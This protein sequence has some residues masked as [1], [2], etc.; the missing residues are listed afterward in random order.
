M[1]KVL[2]RRH[3]AQT[4]KDDASSHEIEYVNKLNL[5]DINAS[6]VTAIFLNSRILPI[7]VVLSRI[8]FFMFLLSIFLSPL[9]YHY[10]EKVIVTTFFAFI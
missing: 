9:L 1:V 5:K 4:V 7:G 10:M 8:F 3:H 6:K 2:L